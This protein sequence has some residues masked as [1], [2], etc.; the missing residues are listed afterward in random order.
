MDRR[1]YVGGVLTA[2]ALGLAGCSDADQT[3][4]DSTPS[5]P[6]ADSTASSTPTQTD[7]PRTVGDT[8]VTASEIALT[9]TGVDTGPRTETDSEQQVFRATIEAEN[10][11]E[12]TQSAPAYLNWH[13]RADGSTF[14]GRDETY[15]QNTSELDPGETG[16]GAV[17][18]SVGN[19]LTRANIENVYLLA[20]DDSL[21]RWTVP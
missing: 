1:G 16:S 18:F 6:T 20:E 7:T 15:G 4:D 17:A 13:L 8:Y 5:T 21:V 9:V 12:S 14:G 10:R 2:V 11:G 19:G 3:P